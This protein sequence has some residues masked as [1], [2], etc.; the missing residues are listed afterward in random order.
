[1]R[2]AAIL[3]FI[4]ITGF[5]FAQNIDSLK[6]ALKNAKQDTTRCNILGVLSETA[7]DGEWEA[8]NDQLKNL[9]EQNIAKGRGPKNFYLQHLALALHN[10]GYIKER[11]GD[12]TKALENYHAGFKIQQ[13]INNKVGM[14][15]SLS[16]FGKIYY[17]Q[18]DIP[19][20]LEYTHKALKIQEEINDRKGEAYSLNNIGFIYKTQGDAEKALEYCTKSLK[21]QEEINN[22][23]GIAIQL[24]NLGYMNEYLGNFPKA[25]GYYQQGLK[26]QEEINDKKAMAYSLNNLASIYNRQG[27]TSEALLYHHKSLK[28]REEMND[29]RAI[30][31]SLINIAGILLKQSEI[32]EALPYANKGFKNAKELGFPDQI[33]DGANILKRIYRKENKDKAALEMYELEILMR[34]SIS[35]EQNKK[36]SIKNQLKYEYEKKA[37]A[38]SI[39]VAEEKKVTTAQLKQEQTQ[40]YALYCVLCLVGLFAVFMVNRFRITNKQKKVIEA[41]K[42]VVEEQK[43]IVDEKQKEILDSINYAKRIQ[44][45]LMPHEKYIARNMYKLRRN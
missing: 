22:R 30:T 17:D 12:I 21:I 8:F 40:R 23:G 3:L 9:A 13:E 5:A 35:N 14:A 7:P 34:D 36:V 1:M 19:K 38:D 15:T 37:A 26:I 32:N 11:E 27:K 31:Y 39:R 24:N 20:A 6:L 18:G 25:I 29:K 4:F 16:N 33:R 42:K 41:Q 44:T 28:I 43:N 45:A 10:K 2:K